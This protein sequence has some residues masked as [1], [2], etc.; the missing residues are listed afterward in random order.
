MLVA[1]DFGLDKPRQI[2]LAGNPAGSDMQ[3]MLGEIY[4]R[5]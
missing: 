1:Y 5:W 2:V 3:A 4:A